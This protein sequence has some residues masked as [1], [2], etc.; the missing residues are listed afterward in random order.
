MTV[1][2]PLVQSQIPV[3]TMAPPPGYTLHQFLPLDG[4]AATVDAASVDVLIRHIVFRHGDQESVVENTLRLRFGAWENPADAQLTLD[5]SID[6]AAWR[7]GSD[8]PFLETHVLVGGDNS[9][10][11][12]YGPSF[13]TVFDSATGKSF[14]N[15][16]AL[17]YANYV[18]IDQIRAFGNWVEGYPACAVDPAHDIDQSV[19]L[20]NP[21][22]RPAVVTLDF[23]GVDLKVRRRIAARSAQ[24]VGF[25]ALLPDDAF[26]WAG[27]CFVSGPNR[28][29][30]FFISHS[31]ADPADITTAEHSEVYRGE[32]A[33]VPMAQRP[34]QRLYRWKRAAF[35]GLR[36]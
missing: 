28:V 34:L 19:L 6:A 29:N 13:Y 12:I 14:F 2:P 16:N 27:Q 3:V 11:T 9:F 20:I 21:H 5:S 8:V 35:N 15:D 36:R 25:A 10:S 24:R 31:L 30:L 7:D 17:K 26:P 23:E 33:Y 22:S 32:D 4:L 1:N 18:V